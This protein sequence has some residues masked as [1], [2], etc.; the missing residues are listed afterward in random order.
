MNTLD[1]TQNSALLSKLEAIIRDYSLSNKGKHLLKRIDDN[2]DWSEIQKM[3]KSN[4]QGNVENTDSDLLVH[5]KCLILEKIFNYT[6]YKLYLEISEVRIFRNFIGIDSLNKI[7][8]IKS[9]S[10]FRNNL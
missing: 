10:N 4:I 7:P 8:K 9:I 1:V 5:L 3:I 6:D 2:I